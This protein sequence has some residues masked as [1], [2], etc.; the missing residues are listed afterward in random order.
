MAST[1]RRAPSSPSIPRAIS[2]TEAPCFANSRTVARPTPADAPVITTTSGFFLITSST[3]LL[4]QFTHFV[5]GYRQRD[6]AAVRLAARQRLG[7]LEQPG[8]HV[9]FAGIGGSYG[10]TTASTMAGPGA[11]RDSFHRAERIASGSSRVKPT[12]PQACAKAAKSMGLQIARRI[13][14]CRAT[15]SAPT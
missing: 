3:P 15:P 10:S 2:P 14:D 12:P 9:T 1:S 7:E 5:G 13:P 8:L 6:L 11:A 4:H